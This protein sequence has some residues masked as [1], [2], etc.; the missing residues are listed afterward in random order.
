[1]STDLKTGIGFLI[2]LGALV[3][4]VLSL[5]AENFMVGILFAVAGILVWFL[6]MAVMETAPPG[7][8]GNVI[9]LFGVLL[10]LGFFLNYGWEQNM[11]GGFELRPDGTI[12]ALII[13]FFTSLLGVV[14][15]RV[16]PARA[17]PPPELTERERELVQKALEEEGAEAEPRV[18]V[19]K[20]EA[21]PVEE[22]EEEAEYEYPYAYPPEYYQYPYY[23]EEYEEEE[24]EE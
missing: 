8:T 4:F 23:E 16:S 14:F 7:V 10:S 21:A 19:V 12:L 5:L 15:R 2:P 3:G 9:I 18:I 11:F 20:P 6:Y 17:A 24:E 22:E 1:M 13:L